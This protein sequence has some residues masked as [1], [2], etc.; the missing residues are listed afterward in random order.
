MRAEYLN[1]LLNTDINDK[2]TVQL[3]YKRDDINFSIANFPYLGSNIPSS[4]E[5]VVFVSHLTRNARACSAYDN[6][7]SRG[8]AT[9]LTY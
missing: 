8:K 2:L 6:I 5:Y 1:I 3:Y 9:V 7:L 4:P